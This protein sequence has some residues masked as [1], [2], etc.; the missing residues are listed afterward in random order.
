MIAE[1]A[2]SLIAVA[3]TLGAVALT[4]WMQQRSNKAQSDDAYRRAQEN[5]GLDVVAMM[6]TVIDAHR[7]TMWTLEANRHAAGGRVSSADLARSHKTRSA[8][9]G[10]LT[11]C[12]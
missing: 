12:M 2:D 3:G 8:I 7:S 6:M 1:W 11:V 5:N 4:A 10:P 9:S